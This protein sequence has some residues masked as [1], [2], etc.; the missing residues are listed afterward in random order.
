MDPAETG[1]RTWAEVDRR[2]YYGQASVATVPE[3]RSLV[4]QQG[5]E[6][7]ARQIDVLV[8]ATFAPAAWAILLFRPALPF[9]PSTPERA[10]LGGIPLQ[11][12]FSPYDLVL[13]L[14]ATGNRGPLRGSAHVLDGWLAGERPILRV[15]TRARGRA[16]EVSWEGAL[17]LKDLEEAQLI[18]TIHSPSEGRL[19]VN[20]HAQSLPTHYGL[21]LPERGNAAHT[22]A[23]PAEPGVLDRTERILR[24]G[25]PVLMAGGLGHIAWRRGATIGLGVDAREVRREYL[26]PLAI[27]GYGV[28]LA[29]GVAW[30]L[31]VLDAQVLAPL[32]CPEERLMLQVVDLGVP[33]KPPPQVSQVPYRVVED[34]SI[35]LGGQSIPVTSLC[36]PTRAARLAGELKSRL[37]RREFPPFL[38]AGSA[39][40]WT[41]EVGR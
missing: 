3:A 19:L 15:Q 39:P 9:L 8:T 5:A 29:V 26:R 22:W 27:P 32:E 16:G 21:L 30:P 37:Q 25:L 40:S 6:E 4:Q 41:G 28:G 11:R 7:V 34:G 36:S 12:G 23:G 24:P 35:E 17:A 10:W 14:G 38:P 13:D 33:Q 31:P 20:S 18:V 1:M 2:L